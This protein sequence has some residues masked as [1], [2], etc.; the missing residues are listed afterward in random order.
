M[1]LAGTGVGWWAANRYLHARVSIA[2]MGEAAAFARIA[3][4]QYDN[5]DYDAARVALRAYLSYLDSQAPGDGLWL[6]AR[7]IA[8]DKAL[9]LSR[10]ALLEEHRQNMAGA[11][12]L[13]S[14]AETAAKAAG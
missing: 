1:L 6:D 12:P 4:V 5:A 13:W 9:V 14:Q 8:A 10:L 3:A 11:E 7:M 2:A